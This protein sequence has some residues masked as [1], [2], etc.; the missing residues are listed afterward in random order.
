MNTTTKKNN[1]PLR[2][3]IV[4]GEHADKRSL[5]RIVRKPDGQLEIDLHGKMP[6]RGAYIQRSIAILAPL[7]A[8]QLIQ[9]HLGVQPDD[10]FYER[11]ARILNE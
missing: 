9:K 4:T 3:C 1:I 10:A 5:L 6:G 2:R 8:S 11:L 7:K